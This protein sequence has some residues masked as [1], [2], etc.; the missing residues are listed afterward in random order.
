MR[1]DPKIIFWVRERY[2]AVEGE[3][4]W[5][6]PFETPISKLGTQKDVFS[7]TTLIVPVKNIPAGNIPI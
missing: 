4:C 6:N 2:K 1:S 3:T 5:S 7:V